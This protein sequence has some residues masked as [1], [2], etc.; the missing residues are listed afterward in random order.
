MAISATD[1]SAQNLAVT[2]NRSSSGR[3]EHGASQT[4][5]LCAPGSRHIGAVAGIE[6]LVDLLLGQRLEPSRAPDVIQE[7]VVGDTVQPGRELTS[8]LEAAD[9]SPSSCDRSPAS[10]RRPSLR[11]R[12]RGE[13]AMHKRPGTYSVP[14][15]PL[16]RHPLVQP[17]ARG[18]LRRRSTV[19][20]RLELSFP[21]LV[22]SPCLVRHRRGKKG[23][24]EEPSKCG[25]RILDRKE[26]SILSPHFR[27]S[28]YQRPRIRRRRPRSRANLPAL[29]P[30]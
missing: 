5:G 3:L 16:L 20:D 14:M 6:K 11:Y 8:T 19:A 7:R 17:S 13:T 10:D 28:S 24:P 18:S 9:R 26:M 29:G 23:N 27:N 30:S 2:A 1:S 22:C 4:L 12:H 25:D 21:L 15:H